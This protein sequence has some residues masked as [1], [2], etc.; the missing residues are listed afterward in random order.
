MSFRRTDVR[1]TDVFRHDGGPI[2]GS[3]KT[4]RTSRHY[5]NERFKGIEPTLCNFPLQFSLHNF[6]QSGWSCLT[7]VIFA[8]HN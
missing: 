6:A 8:S 7:H 2:K 5:V 4:P 3:P 1:E